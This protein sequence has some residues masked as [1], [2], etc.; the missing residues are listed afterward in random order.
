MLRDVV[1]YQERERPAALADLAKVSIEH[2]DKLP[3]GVPSLK[4]RRP[5][6]EG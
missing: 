4:R 2:Y 1:D 6:T 3:K 5:G